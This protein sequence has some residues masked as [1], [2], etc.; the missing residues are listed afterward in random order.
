[1]AA[2][3]PARLAL[4]DEAGG[5]VLVATGRLDVTTVPRLW[6]EASRIAGRG[7]VAVLDLS[8]L[9][10]IDS[11][12]AVL[13]ATAA[14]EAA[15]RGAAEPAAAIIER[16]RRALAAAPPPAPPAPWHPVTDLGRATV[17]QGRSLL[18]GIAF[19]GE[20][21]VTI[22]RA[23][24]HPRLLRR[25][26]LLRFLDEVGT[27]ALPLTLLLGFLIGVIL[28]YQSS[29]PLRRFGAEVFVPNLVGISLLRELGPLL[30]GVVLAGRTGT[31]FAAEIGTMK[32]NEEVDAL[33][34]MGIDPAAMLVLPRILAAALAMPALTLAMNLAGLAGMTLIMATLGYPWAAVEGQLQQWLALGDLLGGLFK[35][36]CFGVIIAGIGCRAGLSTG[37]GPRAVGDSATA[38]VVGGIVAIVALD[39]IFAVLFFRLGI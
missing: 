24:R 9:E 20:T 26:D 11:A 21:V 12:G 23:A 38:A 19:T 39:G 5:A 1:M 29:I 10:A 16:T 3:P 13:L 27:R 33:R 2:T 18:D 30:A 28:A 4:R 35:A 34:V 37:S 17:R 36:V 22:L 8:G 15:L 7:R 31:A 14:P 25:A 32:V 6:S